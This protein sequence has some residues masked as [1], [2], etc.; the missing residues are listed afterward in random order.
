VEYENVLAYLE[1]LEDR[2]KHVEKVIDRHF[3]LI[4][5]NIMK[6]KYQR[7]IKKFKKMKST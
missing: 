7:M 5:E 1:F 4:K 3:N 2:V 6:D